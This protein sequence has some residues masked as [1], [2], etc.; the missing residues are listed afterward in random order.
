MRHA[1]SMSMKFWVEPEL[2]NTINH[3]P[4]TMT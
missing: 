2:S 4:F 1:A 3:A